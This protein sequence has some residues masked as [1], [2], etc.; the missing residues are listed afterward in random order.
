MS[1]LLHLSFA[2]TERVAK[3]PHCGLRALLPLTH[4]RTVAQYLYPRHTDSRQTGSIHPE[5]VTGAGRSFVD[6]ASVVKRGT[7]HPV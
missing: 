7:A 3:T 5:G 1:C 4:R 6:A 2:A